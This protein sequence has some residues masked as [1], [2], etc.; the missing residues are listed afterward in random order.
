MK[1]LSYCR[2]CGRIVMKDAGLPCDYCYYTL[3]AVPKKF[4]ENENLPLINRKLEEQFIN[5]YIKSSREFDQSLFDRRDADLEEYRNQM[6]DV[7]RE[8]KEGSAGPKCPSCGSSNI[9]KIGTV[10]RLISTS[11]FGLASSKIGKTH[12]CNNCG[13]TW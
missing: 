8:A 5:E 4:W 1:S 7:I 2:R 12:K 9:S 11:I 3:S 6:L 13:S 10:N